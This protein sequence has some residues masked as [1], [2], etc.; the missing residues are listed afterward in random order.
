MVFMP[1]CASIIEI[2]PYGTDL[3]Q[4]P[5]NTFVNVAH[6]SGKH[7]HPY[8]S[9]K[10]IDPGFETVD[11]RKMTTQV[12]LDDYMKF[13]R[14]IVDGFGVRCETETSMFGAQTVAMGRG[15]M[16]FAEQIDDA[17]KK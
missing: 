9:T 11:I 14:K 2:F 8:I 1:H 7:Y 5:A 16:K 17:K 3:K 6:F 15:S 10:Y 12:E 13:F 4:H